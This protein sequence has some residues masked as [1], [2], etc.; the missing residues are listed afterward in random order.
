VGSI[1]S[2]LPG[3][4]RPR[5][6]LPGAQRWPIEPAQPS[7]GL[8]YSEWFQAG[9]AGQLIGECRVCRVQITVFPFQKCAA[10]LDSIG[11]RRQCGNVA[12]N[13]LG[14]I[15]SIYGPMGWKG[16]D[17][18]ENCKYR[19]FAFLLPCEYAV[20]QRRIGNYIG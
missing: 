1:A 6:A 2:W 17:V 16:S 8:P 18:V 7:A 13:L 10:E 3:I 11:F 20:K 4:T 9:N 12:L 15:K 5:F 14:D 19:D